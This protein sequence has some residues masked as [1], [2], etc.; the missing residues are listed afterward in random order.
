MLVFDVIIAFFLAILICA[1]LDSTPY[2]RKVTDVL[3]M[4]TLWHL[5]LLYGVFG[6]LLG[7]K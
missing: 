1:L 3:L 2:G 6:S 7:K 5:A 4:L